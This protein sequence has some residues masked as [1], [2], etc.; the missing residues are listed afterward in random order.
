[1][2]C[3]LAGLARP[4][5]ISKHRRSVQCPQQRLDC[6]RRRRSDLLVSVRYSA[7]DCGFCVHPSQTLSRRQAGSQPFFLAAKVC[8]AYAKI[9]SG[10]GQSKKSKVTGDSFLAASRTPST[11]VRLAFRF[12]ALTHVRL[13]I[14]DA[15]LTISSCQL[16]LVG[17]GIHRGHLRS[18]VPSTFAPLMFRL[19]CLPSH[20]LLGSLMPT[21]EVACARVTLAIAK[22]GLGAQ[23]RWVEGWEVTERLWELVWVVDWARRSGRSREERGALFWSGVSFSS[24]SPSC[25][26]HHHSPF[27]PSSFRVVIDVCTCYLPLQCNVF[28]THTFDSLARPPRLVQYTHNA[29]MALLLNSSTGLAFCRC[30]L[31][32]RA[33]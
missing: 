21:R 22:S 14:C 9:F 24:Y 10:Q 5:G 29:A 15:L 20:F 30:S 19:S 31:C 7:D 6:L 1:M 3:Q 13:A 26:A 16:V 4:E 17:Q 11:S 32:D 12:L 27:C 18:S 8:C 33:W 2:S 23:V 25:F 28:T